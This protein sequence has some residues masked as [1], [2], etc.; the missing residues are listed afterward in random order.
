M[1]RPQFSLRLLFLAITLCAGLAGWCV[2][3]RTDE[4]ADRFYRAGVYQREL[5]E[6]RD[7]AT[8][9]ERELAEQNLSTEHRKQRV[10]DVAILKNTIK[11]LER[12]IEDL[13][14]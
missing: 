13:N 3:I 10:E 1:K 2:V 6:Y 4:R 5:D 14:R 11:N 9:M 12:Q 7:S 8:Y